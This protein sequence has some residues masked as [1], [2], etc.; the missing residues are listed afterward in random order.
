MQANYFYSRRP[1][2]HPGGGHAQGACTPVFLVNISASAGR[3]G[4]PKKVGGKNSSEEAAGARLRLVGSLRR[5]RAWGFLPSRNPLAK[6]RAARRALRR[7]GSRSGRPGAPAENNAST[8]A[9]SRARLRTCERALTSGAPHEN[10]ER[11]KKN[12]PTS[13]VNHQKFCRHR[14]GGLWKD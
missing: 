3:G 1:S 10:A 8:H 14:T 4:D 5:P 13:Q 9:T 11:Q 6:C 12:S 7:R 2:A